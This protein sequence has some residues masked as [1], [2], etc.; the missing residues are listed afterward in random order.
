MEVVL[1]RISMFHDLFTPPLFINNKNM[2]K[3]MRVKLLYFFASLHLILYLI[4]LEVYHINLIQP[5][6]S[7]LV[8][9][10][11]TVEV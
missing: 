2:E 1:C 5:R 3:V 7:A 6:G 8:V 9:A 10:H 11:S 4:V